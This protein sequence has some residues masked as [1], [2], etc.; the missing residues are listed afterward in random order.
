ME[1]KNWKSSILW[2]LGLVIVLIVLDSI[3]HSINSI[4]SISKSLEKRIEQ[5]YNSIEKDGIKLIYQD[6]VL[7][8]WSS[9]QIAVDRIYSEDYNNSFLKIGSSYYLLSNKAL[10]DSIILFAK[11]IKHEREIN[12]KYL[13]DRFNPSLGLGH[14]E[15]LEIS[16]SKG[17]PIKLEDKTIFYLD[18]SKSRISSKYY[19]ANLSLIAFLILLIIIGIRISWTGPKPWWKRIVYILLFV[20]GYSVLRYLNLPILTHSSILYQNKG[21]YNLGDLGFILV[22]FYI[23]VYGIKMEKPIR[24]KHLR[25]VILILLGLAINLGFIYISLNHLNIRIDL[26]TAIAINKNMYFLFF[27]LVISQ[28]IFY[29]YIRK[30]IRSSFP[31]KLRLDSVKSKA[32][33]LI[34][35][36]FAI[37]WMIYSHNIKEDR[38]NILI[39]LRALS[40]TT[41]PIAE[42]ALGEIGD[43][44]IENEDYLNSLSKEETE[45]NIR[46]ITLSKLSNQYHIGV[47]V[48]E[49]GDDIIISPQNMEVECIEYFHTRLQDAEAIDSNLSIFIDN[50]LINQTAYM[51]VFEVVSETNPRYIFIDCLRRTDS[52]EMSYPDLLLDEENKRIHE[53][54]IDNYGI[55]IDNELVFQ[56]GNIA[57]PNIENLETNAWN[58]IS[59]KS[60]YLL[61]CK[62]GRK[63]W[64]VEKPRSGFWAYL[65]V[66]SFTALLSTII[67][68]IALFIFSKKIRSRFRDL[69]ISSNIEA[70]I[71]FIFV[72]SFIVFGS[73]SLKYYSELNLDGNTDTLLEK[74]QSISY[75]IQELLE[76]DQAYELENEIH[77]LSNIFLTDINIFDKEGFLTHSSRPEVF[78]KKL[79]SKQINPETFGSLGHSPILILE[80][81]IGNR[82]YLAS[83]MPILYEGDLLGYIHIPFIIQQRKLE[84]KIIE[85]INTFS[86]A[87]IVWVLFSILFAYILSKYITRPLRKVRDMI[88]IINLEKNEKIDW[89]RSDELGDL[90]ESYNE[91]VEKLEASAILLQKTEREKAWRELAKQVA[92]DIKNP[93]TPIKLSIQQL[94]RLQITDRPSF[95]KRFSEVS[96]SIIDQIN[97][98]SEIANELSDYSLSTERK[99]ESCNLVEC[100]NHVVDIHRTSN[101]V[102]IE[103]INHSNKKGIISTDKQSLIRI[104]NNLV[105]NSVQAIPE[106]RDG[107]IEIRL[108]DRDNRFYIEIEDNGIGISEENQSKIFSNEFTTKKDGT[109]IGLSI[110]KSIIESIG[111]EIEF[112]SVE[113][114]GSIFRVILEQ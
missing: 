14:I 42:E 41:D 102:E 63:K 78:D 113:N 44:I 8:Y 22:I 101:N 97:T 110:V 95:E 2:I 87:Y 77:K 47:I 17:N 30:I 99:N 4:S 105:K 98:L 67:L 24:N 107:R 23:I 85:F 84:E 32:L 9:N 11:P 56:Y 59:N 21:V 76:D 12:N 49:D 57:Y 36:S 33:I 106:D 103:L 10:G 112:S 93:L 28:L 3:S 88:S 5:E 7:V 79:I 26:E 58:T 19:L 61:E 114:K 37:G 91:M 46:D 109:G 68:S 18:S 104:L 92:H 70:I 96:S 27:L 71:I 53:N 25:G 69:G 86:N 15:D 38:E 50:S 55:Y 90:I 20:L 40:E 52:K 6:S 29:I 74:T 75:K 1:I 48:C 72:L 13:K 54:K 111:G 43:Y 83:Y 35:F 34:L 65:S 45:L 94:Q 31:R 100:L 81:N 82:E 60:Y 80:E 108:I 66:V 89:K 73:I 62:D 64:L 16:L 51:G 39:G